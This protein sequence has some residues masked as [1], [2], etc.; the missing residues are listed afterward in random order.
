MI[1][2]FACANVDFMERFDQGGEIVC[3]KCLGRK[4]IIG[5]DYEYLEGPTQCFECGHNDLEEILIGHCMNCSNR[6][7]FEKATSLEIIGYR[8]NRLEPLALLH[9]A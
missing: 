1:H 5:A 8:V 9:T 4:M 3:P 2:H 6:F 7:P